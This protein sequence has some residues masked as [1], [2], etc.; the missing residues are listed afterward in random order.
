MEILGTLEERIASKIDDLSPKH[1]EIARFMLDN[2][3]FMSFVSA[4]QAGEKNGTSAATIVRFAQA[5]GYEGYPELQEALRG[6]LPTYITSVTRMQRRMHAEKPPASTTQEVFYTDIKNLEQTAGSLSEDSL[7]AAV[8]KI[9]AARR[10]LVIGA[11]LSFAPAIFLSHS[12]K[13]MGFDVIAVQGEG[14]QAA[15]E[16]ARMRSDDLLVAIDLWRY[17]RMT[18]NAVSKAKEVGAPVIVMTDSVVS[19]LTHQ[20]DIAFE[21][22]T[23]GVA[24][25]L[26]TTALMS[27]LNVIVARLA[28]RLPDQ[29]FEALQRVDAMYRSNDLLLT[30]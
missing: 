25:S 16:L 27:L 10:I 18:V 8:E 2:R 28:D 13:V 19:P 26:S 4:S 17:V 29:V 5:L 21:V 23:Q 11:G 22:A 24:H 6:E 3:Y 15:V 1:K 12:L 14:L 20:A 9:A 7:N 30:E